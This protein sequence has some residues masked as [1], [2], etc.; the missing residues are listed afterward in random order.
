MKSKIII[1]A[2]RL[3]DEHDAKLEALC[4]SA[5]LEVDGFSKRVV[6]R[7]RRGICIRRWTLPLAIMVGG[8]IAAK[9]AAELL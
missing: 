5:P 4:R 9:P 2:E 8:L 3:K 6:W 1:M 7:V